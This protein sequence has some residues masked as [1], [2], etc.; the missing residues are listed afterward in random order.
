MASSPSYAPDESKSTIIQEETWLQGAFLSSLFFGIETT[1][2]TLTFLAILR[3]RTPR[4]SRM[5]I[6][7]LVYVAV[8]FAIMTTSQG[9]LLDWIQM[10]FITQRNY[11]GGPSAFLNNEWSVPPSV[12]Q[13]ILLVV[14]NWMMESLLVWRCRVVC[15]TGERLWWLGVAI[16]LPFFIAMFVTGSLVV[17]HSLQ[18]SP[19]TIY[20]LAYSISSLA[21]NLAATGFIAGR[22]LVHRRCIVSQLGRGHGHLYVSIA[23]V[24]VE[25]A[26]IYTSFLVI[27]IIV[28]AL[29]SPGVNI[30]LQVIFHVQTITSLLIIWRI[31]RGEGWTNATPGTQVAS[32][33]ASSSNT[34][35][36]PRS[37]PNVIHLEVLSI[38]RDEDDGSIQRKEDESKVS[39]PKWWGGVRLMRYLDRR[40]GK[41]HKGC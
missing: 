27:V 9:L 13:T 22:L 14:A 40:W 11:P 2:S 10:G 34:P 6:I 28:Y 41:A 26:A 33:V 30:L 36:G 35:V 37:E 1:L 5:D 19:P 38:R 15:G 12:A 4:R 25:S 21:L 18:T 29:G 23:A 7:L 20:I 17:Y 16:P 24:V 31:A 32:M 3:R 39:F 8:L